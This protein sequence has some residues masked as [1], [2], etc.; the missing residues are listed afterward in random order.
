MHVLVIGGNRFMGIG[1]TWR[2][3]AAGHRVTHF[4]RGG[5]PDPFGERV[6]RLRGDRTTLDFRTRLGGRSFD[7]V[8]D[9]AGFK[10]SDVRACASILKGRV[11]HYLFISTGQVYLVRQGCPSPAGERDYDGAL[12]ARPDE[13]ADISE[14]EYG[15]GKRDC[16][17]VLAEAWARERFPSTR[18]RLPMVD[19]ERDPQRRLEAYLWRILDGGPVILPDGGQRPVRH[20]YAGA[21]VRA[22]VELLGR[23]DSFGRAFNLSQDEMPTLAEYV[24]LLARLLGA[25][26]RARGV[27][28]AAIRA[29]GLEPRGVS[30]FSVQW[31]SCIDPSL[32]KTEL[33]FR[34]E[35]LEEYLGRIVASFLAHP[36][37]EPPASYARRGDEVTLAASLS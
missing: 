20:V 4:N 15:V 34:H 23:Q 21:V 14:W 26:A 12:I 30:P 18:L 3:L 28:S 1:L 16:E 32:A 24:A 7:A 31:M 36:P 27:A 10:G 17:D 25:P 11:G 8:V 13:P 9:F 29:A 5:L 6:E 35:P 37:A 22:I 2:L 33:G 19:G